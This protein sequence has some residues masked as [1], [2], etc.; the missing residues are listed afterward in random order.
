M[1]KYFIIIVIL[2]VVLLITIGFCVKTVFTEGRHY[3]DVDTGVYAQVN[4]DKTLPN[5]YGYDQ[6]LINNKEYSLLLDNYTNIYHATKEAKLLKPF[7]NFGDEQQY[8]LYEVES[9]CDF[10]IYVDSKNSA[11]FCERINIE[12]FNDYY[13]DY[14][15]FYFY[16]YIDKNDDKI[17]KTNIDSTKYSNLIEKYEDN[18]HIDSVNEKKK[19]SSWLTIVPVSKDKL[20]QDWQT[21]LYKIGNS[22]YMHR[23]LGDIKLSDEDAEYFLQFFK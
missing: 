19:D 11:L 4:T 3:E 1:K 7:A 22:V 8:T 10:S 20:Y 15:N 2:A 21:D 17:K 5:I 14:N 23:G 12:A 18:P 13:T 6:L 9:D 16:S